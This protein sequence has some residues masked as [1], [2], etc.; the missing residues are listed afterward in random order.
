MKMSG[1]MAKQL[2]PTHLGPGESNSSTPK[3]PGILTVTLHEAEGVGLSAPNHYK[4][5]SI[6]RDH[7]HAAQGAFPARCR[8][9]NR[10]YALLDYE[11]CQVV[12]DPFWGTA[13]RPV[14]KGHACKFDVSRFAELTIFLYLPDRNASRG[15]R[16]QDMFVGT[17]RIDLVE[18]LGE[19]GAQWVE[20]QDGTGRIR[21][22]FEY[23][24]V[25]TGTLDTSAF[26]NIWSGR[27]RKE[28]TQ[29]TYVEKRIPASEAAHPRQISHP[30]IAPLMF[31]FRSLDGLHLLSPHVRG[32]HLFHYLQR[33]RRFDLER[34]R[35]YVSE[36]LCA[37]EYLHDVHGLFS[38]LKPRNVLL[39]SV[40]HVVL[41]GFGLF[42]NSGIIHEIPE[43][44]APEVLLG[45]DDSRTADW[46][47]LGVF[48]YEMLTGLTPFYDDDF[49]EVRCK[50]L[51][52]QPVPFPES[53]PLNAKDPM[54]KLLDRRPE[55]RLGANGGASEVKG[56]PFFYGVDWH[57]L[58]QRKYQPAFKPN[59]IE[60][61]EFKQHG[62]H[63]PTASFQI[64]SYNRPIPVRTT[65]PDTG[66]A[67]TSEVRQQYIRE[68]DDGWELV[69][70]PVPGKFHF[71][72]HFTGTKQAVPPRHADSFAHREL[73]TA[74][75]RD[76]SADPTVPSQS[77]KQDVLE[78]ALQAGYDRAIAQLLE[79]YG[80]TDL[81]IWISVGKPP[82][83]TTPLQ[84]ATEQENPVLVSLFLEK[85]AD[86]SFLNASISGGMHQG[87][88]A[89]IK[90]VE[91]GNRELATLLVSKTDRVASTRALG[92]AVDRGDRA[93]TALLL[94]KG[95]R[96]DYEVGDRPDPQHPE[97]DAC[98][99]FDL[100]EP[101]EFMSP[102]VR[103]VKHC[104]A[105]LARL[106]LSHGAD[107]NAGY[108][109]LR[110]DQMER[111]PHGREDAGRFSC[112][113]VVELAMVLGQLE[114]V[115]LLLAAS[116]DIGLAQP[117]WNVKGHDC[118][119]V[120]RDVYQRVAAGLRAAAAAAAKTESEAT[121]IESGN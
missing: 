29:L 14:W 39:D 75:I 66:N 18:G 37:L 25:S 36:I 7:D 59:C 82:G 112:G 21:I 68:K 121:A 10:P 32:G 61:S 57:K 60:E 81:N 110:W 22:S 118:K 51:L 15:E 44:P 5:R 97:D 19:P 115:Q 69:W 76:H 38:W 4:Q 33:E 98:Y 104:D 120:P 48:L 53:I 54:M 119:L 85:G 42:K 26:K 101:D 6:A 77:Q 2:G 116:A 40:G 117:I 3:T 9:C 108:H 88:P 94:G 84:W 70:E 90:A 41:C 107:A 35:F 58:L 109:D 105:D 86:A 47:T 111:P 102:L 11:K 93:M 30:F 100:S 1:E 91:K 99:F 64:F 71:Y 28:D 20:I 31:S 72:N 13:E 17:A 73:E 78:A 103:A 50:I 67:P 63:K 45:Q 16:G 95:V 34:S 24:S 49:A 92:L 52:D 113:R 65:R 23:Q 106:L 83:R 8:R 55:Q 74:T 96:C 62:V 114:I 89:L 43:Y 80:A 87:G 12:L 46:W 79:K 27:V 56:H